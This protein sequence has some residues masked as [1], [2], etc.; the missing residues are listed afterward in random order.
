MKTPI[1]TGI[2]QSDLDAS[3]YKLVGLP[4]P[5]ASTD[6]ANKAYVDANVGGGGGG[7]TTVVLSPGSHQVTATELLNAI[8]GTR[9][10]IAALATGLGNF[11]D[12]QSMDPCVIVNP[13]DSTQLIMLFTGLAAPVGTGPITIG[14]ATAS[15]SDPTTW[16]V[17]NSGNPGD[18]AT[19]SYETGGMGLRCRLAALQSRRRQTVSVLHGQG[20]CCVSDV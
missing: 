5:V 12:S 15:V 18:D 4:L 6:A 17:S 10:P 7:G 1:Y 20:R 16:T 19:L 14:R 8:A 13:S 2:F 3:G 9:Y 11:F